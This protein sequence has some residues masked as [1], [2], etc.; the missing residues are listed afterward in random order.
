MFVLLGGNGHI[1]GSLARRLLADGHPVR[2]VGRDASRLQPLVRAGAQIA[3]G[4][5]ADADFLARAFAGARGAY[6]MT[7]HA[8][9]APDMR[10]SQDRI[11]TAVA[12]AL[13]QARPARVV[14][15]SS[16]GAERASGTGPIVSLHA[17]ERRLDAIGGLDLLHLRPAWF[18]ENLLEMLPGVE[19]SGVLSSMEA[20]DVPIPMAATRDIAAVAAR[21]LVHPSARGPLLLRAPATPTLR[22][23]A[24]VIGE[25]LGRP[26]LDYRQADPAEARALLLS[27]GFSEDVV[28]QLAALARWLSTDASSSLQGVP[29]ELLP[30]SLEQFVGEQ[31]PVTA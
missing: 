25:A 26:G 2:V 1:T 16:V 29:V 30:T 15:L 17:Q 28:D 19:A 9:D 5:A 4:D 7:P 24:A 18:M 31:L 3:V 22:E 13:A 14:N 12:R 20:G 10:A 23:A 8:P 27:L 6:V 11:G 21:E